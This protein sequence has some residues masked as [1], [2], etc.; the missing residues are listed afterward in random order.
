M[1]H[2][3]A[4]VAEKIFM[5]GKKAIVLEAKDPTLQCL[6]KMRDEVHRVAINFQRRLLQKSSLS[7]IFDDIKG[8]GPK[9]KKLL[10]TRFKSLKELK[11]ELQCGAVA[12]LSKQDVKNLVGELERN[13]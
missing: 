3:K 5:E 8:I 9:K 13:G 10:L 1:T 12:G 4:L 7:T 6:Q 11:K 2:A